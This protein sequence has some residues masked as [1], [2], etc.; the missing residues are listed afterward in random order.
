MFGYDGPVEGYGF[1]LR[2]NGGLMVGMAVFGRD[3]RVGVK[4]WL[5]CGALPARNKLNMGD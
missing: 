2:R 4:G 1:R 5:V 3:R